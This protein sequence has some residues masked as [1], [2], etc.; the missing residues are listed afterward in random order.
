M[1][2]AMVSDIWMAVSWNQAMAG[3]A[4][5]GRA[6]ITCLRRPP[7]ASLVRATPVITAG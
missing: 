2:T 5:I 1:Q 6:E 3:K 4:C 7:Q